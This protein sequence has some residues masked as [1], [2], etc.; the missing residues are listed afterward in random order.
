LSRL[1]PATL[2]HCRAGPPPSN[3]AG[4]SGAAKAVGGQ[5]RRQ[6]LGER[7]QIGA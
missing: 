7:R 6:R 3:R 4:A 2:N 1:I 5:E